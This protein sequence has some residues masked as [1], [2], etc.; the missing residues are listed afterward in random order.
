M[1]ADACSISAVFLAVHFRVLPC[2]VVLVLGSLQVMTKRNPGMM[3]GLLVIARLVMLGSLAMMFGSLLVV[4]RG[5]LVV[6]VDLV[7]S[8]PVLPEI[9][10]LSG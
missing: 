10:E 7:L 1:S 6:L 9:R 8:H 2:G 5:F 4:L 3:R